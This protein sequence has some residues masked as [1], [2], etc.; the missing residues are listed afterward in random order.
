MPRSEESKSCLPPEYEKL[1]CYGDKKN[2]TA[3]CAAGRFENKCMAVGGVCRNP[4]RN[5]EELCP[6]IM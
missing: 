4:K 2:K 5:G 1:K 3:G 6:T